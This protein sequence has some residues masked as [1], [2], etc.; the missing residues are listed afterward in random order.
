MS[1]NNVGFEVEY[2]AICAI[3]NAMKKKT[4]IPERRSV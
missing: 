1:E 3:I 2:C 4:E